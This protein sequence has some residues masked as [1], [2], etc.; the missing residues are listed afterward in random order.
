M[1]ADKAGSHLV[2]VYLEKPEEGTWSRRKGARVFLGV[3]FPQPDFWP[4]NLVGVPIS[5]TFYKMPSCGRLFGG[6]EIRAVSGEPICKT[7]DLVFHWDRAASGRVSF[8]VLRQ[9]TH[10]MTVGPRALQQIGVDWMDKTPSPI[11]ATTTADEDLLRQLQQPAFLEPG[12]LVLS[13]GDTPTGTIEE[14][15]MALR[16][17][18]AA[19][20]SVDV[21]VR[22]GWPEPLNGIQPS[23]DVCCFPS[24]IRV[25]KAKAASKRTKDTSGGAVLA[26][27]A[28]R[29]VEGGQ[30]EQQCV[31]V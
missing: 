28:P 8:D 21:A 4:A 2:R 25:P 7:Q 9:E 20:G 10:R 30:D 17:A 12:D 19:G 13:V 18:A 22:R 26:D 3:A 14:A 11:V 16:D 24:T 27:L 1:A 5:C 31:D 23:C 15:T 6:D 29:L